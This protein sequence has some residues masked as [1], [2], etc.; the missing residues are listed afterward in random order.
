MERRLARGTPFVRWVP[1]A[2]LVVGVAFDTFTPDGYNGGPL[3]AV[4]CVT[5]GATLRLRPTLLVSAFAAVIAAGLSMRH[6]TFGHARGVSEIGNVLLAGLGALYVNQVIRRQ[7]R[8]L[9]EVSS[10]AEAAQRAVL[11]VPPASLGPLR[12]AARYEAAQSEARI[13][14]DAYAVQGTPYGARFLIGD[15]RGKGMGAVGAVSVLLG[16]FREAAEREP[17]L[18]SLADR[19]EHAL[20][21]EGERRQDLDQEEGFTTALLGEITPDG[22]TLRLLSRGHPPPY[23]LEGTSVRTLTPA[24]ADL[25]L[26]LGRLT[27]GRSMPDVFTLSPRA[28]LL[29]VTD[30][31]TEA[32][33]GAGEFYDP[34][35][36]LGRWGPYPS[37]QAVVTSLARDVALWTGG[38]STDDMAVL[39][40]SRAGGG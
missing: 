20:L 16:A 30:G 29:L 18:P 14:G 13:G 32:R 33:D 38:R 24:Q 25:P 27:A 39:A 35:V 36:R 28:V 26:S 1:A 3:L 7:G 5:A 8:R 21:R 11:P 15:V 34:A 37:P 17:D 23:L 22:A 10:V 12:I 40:I 31:V 6:G 9:T 4:A 2:T 19:L